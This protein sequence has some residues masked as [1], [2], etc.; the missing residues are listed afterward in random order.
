MRAMPM[1]RV[2]LSLLLAAVL[3][4]LFLVAV[5]EGRFASPGRR[6]AALAAIA[7]AAFLAWLI[8]FPAR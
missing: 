3:L 7:A 6:L 2:L 1:V 5:R 8:P 4:L